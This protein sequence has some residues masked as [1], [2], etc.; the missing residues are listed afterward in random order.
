MASH[1]QIWAWE[2][3]CS[4]IPPDNTGHKPWGESQARPRQGRLQGWTQVGGDLAC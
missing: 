1:P 3:K 2:L 4:A